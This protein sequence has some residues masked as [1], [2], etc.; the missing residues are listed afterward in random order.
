M[1]RLDGR[2]FSVLEVYNSITAVLLFIIHSIWH[3][4][5]LQYYTFY[6]DYR[7]TTD[8]TMFMFLESVFG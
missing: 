3:I 4:A 1:Q 5:I 8:N 2:I 6:T 7:M